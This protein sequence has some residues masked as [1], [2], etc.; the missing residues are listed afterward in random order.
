MPLIRRWSGGISPFDTLYD[1]RREVDRMLNDFPAA[2]AGRADSWSMPAEVVE[3]GDEVRLMIEAPGL[4]P[5]DIDITLEN[6]VLTVSGEKKMERREG[7]SEND[8]RLLERRYGR[9]ERSFVLP[10]TVDTEHVDA[11][12]ENGILTV[13]LPKAESSKPRR[14]Q[15]QGGQGKR[16][17]EAGK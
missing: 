6:N 17:F 11:R 13:Q 2:S 8:Y 4:K 9:F 12:Y 16:R 1:V 10:P 3:T 14:I 5:E 7:E 15:V